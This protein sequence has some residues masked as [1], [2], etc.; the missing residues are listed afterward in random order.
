[1]DAVRTILIFTVL[2]IAL[3]A[4][5]GGGGSGGSGGGE[6]PENPENPGNPEPIKT[7]NLSDALYDIPE[8]Q[9]YQP[10]YLHPSYDG[11]IEQASLTRQNSF[12]FVEAVYVLL[13]PIFEAGTT[14]FYVAKPEILD[15]PYSGPSD[16]NCING[17]LEHA[18]HEL[19]DRV[20]QVVTLDH[21]QSRGQGEAH[22]Q[23]ISEVFIGAD[24]RP[25]HSISTYRDL[26]LEVD[27]K[28]LNYYGQI[29]TT[30]K[31]HM[32]V[33]YLTIRNSSLDAIYHTQGLESTLGVLSGPIYHSRWGY[34]ELKAN[35]RR[36]LSTQLEGAEGGG[37]D[38]TLYR[39]NTERALELSLSSPEIES[40]FAAPA[41]TTVVPL[42]ELFLWPYRENQAPQGQV[43][44]PEVIAPGQTMTL[45]ATDFF[46]P[47]YDFVTHTW[48]YLSKPDGCSGTLPKNDPVVELPDACRGTYELELLVS[49]GFNDVSLPVEV[50]VGG[51]LPQVEE[52]VTLELES[53]SEALSLQ[54]EVSN[55]AETGPLN[56][57]IAYAPPGI[58]VSPSGLVTG[59]PERLFQTKGGSV[60]I[61]V[62]VS[63]ERSVVQEFT[64]NYTNRELEIAATNRGG[65]PDD[66][67]RGW[68]DINKDGDPEQLVDYSST[69]AIIEVHDGATRYRHL[70][71]RAFSTDS[72]RD[73]TVTDYDADGQLDIV[74]L[75]PDTYI[76]LSGLDFSV[77]DEVPRS[78]SIAQQRVAELFPGGPV[79]MG[80]IDGDSVDDILQLTSNIA[81]DEFTIE[82]YSND[83]ETLLE[84]YTVNVPELDGEYW[85]NARFVNLDDEPGDELVLAVYQS[86]QLY[87]LKRTDT[88]FEL[89][90][91]VTYPERGD[92]T[93]LSR[94][95]SL[96]QFTDH[97]AAM[98]GGADDGQLFRF[99]L[100]EAPVHYASGFQHYS[101]EPDS[102]N[103]LHRVRTGPSSI[104]VL[105]VRQ[106][107][108]EQGERQTELTAS[109]LNAD[110]AWTE[111]QRFP[112]LPTPYYLNEVANISSANGPHNVWLY[113]H[114][115]PGYSVIDP[116]LGTSIFSAEVVAIKKAVGDLDGDGRV[117]AYAINNTELYRLNSD[118]Y[119]FELIDNALAERPAGR[120]NPFVAKFDGNQPALFI[121]WEFWNG[122]ITP[123]LDVY[124]YHDS[125]IQ[126][127]GTIT[128]DTD[129]QFMGHAEQ[130]VT[131]DGVPELIVWNTDEQT[132]FWIIDSSLSVVAQFTT[133]TIVDGVF[134]LPDLQ[135]DS[136]V[137]YQ[138]GQ[139]RG[140]WRDTH[141]IQI[142][143]NSG[144]IFT[145]SPILPGWPDKNG[146][147]CLGDS[148]ADCTKLV[149]TS[150]GVFSLK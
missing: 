2:T 146:L 54:V 104:D 64:V 15:Y 67:S 141:I 94:L 147:T 5:G 119:E 86:D 24:G 110:L 6:G 137:A 140:N 33:D 131:G 135:S 10:V 97:S 31:R 105:G 123:R 62:E 149:V 50:V 49:D 42:T 126:R 11:S 43:D 18:Q 47:D 78:S 27:G 143:P 133:E 132:E 51:P 40:Q 88:V 144:N 150:L 73:K 85:F 52:K 108:N 9:S 82:H 13:D 103:G 16:L 44:A 118:T 61:G 66:L 130:D 55:A 99:S 93:A 109:T 14:Q 39:D 20:V 25:T 45:D 37:L 76:V 117:E 26:T 77:I 38:M 28:R 32:I 89:S 142:D 127:T 35:Q 1:M 69:F 57:A 19:A 90:Q 74:L 100:I 30:D 91:K 46:D 96:S 111:H 83:S 7:G 60:H 65:A 145:R 79:P 102:V 139:G 116:T 84:T 128:F 115:P 41:I 134:E 48:R 72:L 95:D 148:L 71:T 23:I 8:I 81:V 112:G 121:P 101:L 56:Y 12:Y 138:Q 122:G 75:Y 125:A 136:L 124:Q 113:A 53:A 98:Q 106:W 3:T 68:Q 107:L 70:E 87:L 120:E 4:C 114:W 36:S 80:D 17:S 59:I 21:C 22:G 34:V 63:N 29:T 129:P 92:H 58:E